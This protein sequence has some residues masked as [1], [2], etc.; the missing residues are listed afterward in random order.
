MSS[1]RAPEARTTTGQNAGRTGNAPRSG[2]SRKSGSPASRSGVPRGATVRSRGLGT[3]IRNLR[4]AA[5]LRLEQ[6]AQRC[7]WS[8][9]TLGRIESGERIPSETEM[10]TLLGTLGITGSERTR[11]FE[12][13]QAAAEPRWWE[14]GGHTGTPAALAALIDF[15]RFATEIT[16]LSL[17]RV[18]DLL[19][20][21]DYARAV[22]TAT[23]LDG[24]DL[25]S[26]VALRLGRQGVLTRR[27]PVR[28]QAYLDEAVLRRPVGGPAVLADQLRHLL[29]MAQRPNISVHLLPF[30]AGAHAGLDGDQLLL[31]FERQRPI[32]HVENLRSGEFLDD[33]ADTAPFFDAL[34]R[35][36]AVSLPAGES[37]RL[38]TERAAELER[39]AVRQSD[40][41]A[42]P[43]G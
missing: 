32:V 31:Q 1:V 19:Q 22:L 38:I 30:A 4:K 29:R 21:P 12:L 27:H 23:G 25:E 39:E 16:D 8:R 36:A 11:L 6:L 35:V 15:E 3:E 18:P 37:V 13:V 42:R 9:A 2:G 20:T 7:G 17:T 10:A 14:V 34:S 33:A 26:R 28:F 41:A 24:P 43:L 5:G 40:R